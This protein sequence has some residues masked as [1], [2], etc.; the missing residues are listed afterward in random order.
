[1]YSYNEPAGA[2]GRSGINLIGQVGIYN[3]NLFRKL[4]KILRSV[5]QTC[6]GSKGCLVCPDSFPA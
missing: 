6:P 4:T 3:Y 5:G 1:E 2:P